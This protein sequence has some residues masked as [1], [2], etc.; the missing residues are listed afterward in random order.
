MR[1]RDFLVYSGLGIIVRDWG[2]KQEVQPVSK[3]QDSKPPKTFKEKTDRKVNYIV[4]INLEELRGDSEENSIR[5]LVESYIKKNKESDMTVVLENYGNCRV[6]LS[7]ADT[8]STLPIPAGD[9]KVRKS[10]GKDYELIFFFSGPPGLLKS[11]GEKAA[12]KLR[13]FSRTEYTAPSRL[14][15]K[16]PSFR[17]VHERTRKDSIY[18]NE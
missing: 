1:R 12:E 17:E 9:H 7:S 4:R 16:D 13:D 2:C 6:S 10:Y 11:P 15:E 3:P 5:P 18:R 14:L 8:G